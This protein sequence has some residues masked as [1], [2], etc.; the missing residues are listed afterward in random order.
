MKYLLSTL[1]FI[2]GFQNGFSQKIIN[3]PAVRT[4][5]KDIHSD[6]ENGVCFFVDKRINKK[7]E[8]KYAFFLKKLAPKDTPILSYYDYKVQ[9]GVLKSG[10]KTGLW[11]TTYKNKIVKTINYNNGLVIGKYRVYNTKKELLYKTTFGTNGNGKFKDFSY[12]T[13]VLKQEG[14]YQNGKKEGEW[15]D[16]DEQ[17]NPKKIRYYKKGIL[18]ER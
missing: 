8:G 14:N 16:Y 2:I 3:A 12:K 11:Q 18:V 7:M 6:S 15:C 13:G 10:Y 5:L 1:I 4:H 17:G 9:E